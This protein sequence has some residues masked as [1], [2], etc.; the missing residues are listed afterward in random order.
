MSIKLR[1]LGTGGAFTRYGDNYHNNCII[2]LKNDK[3]ILVDCGTTAPQ[4]LFELNISPHQISDVLITHMHADHCGGLEQLIWE[5]F[6]TGFKGP[7]FL[8][9]RIHC[10]YSLR[11]LLVSYLGQVLPPYTT[12]AGTYSND[13]LDN[14]VEIIPQENLFNIE[15]LDIEFN[16]VPHVRDSNHNKPSYGIEFIE[17]SN[18][19]YYSGDTTLDV[20]KIET[21]KDFDVIFHECMFFPKYQGTVHTHYDE[22]VAIDPSIK[23]KIVLMHYG[24]LPDGV[25]IDKQGFKGAAQRFEEFLIG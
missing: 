17:N 16:S 12:P 23:S 20:E 6:Y 24:K 5:R 11:P 2:E 25:D 8:K 19:I 13:W 15:H 21:M 14:L 22:L 7:E 1:F 18:R 4:A 3:Y 9:T 10:A